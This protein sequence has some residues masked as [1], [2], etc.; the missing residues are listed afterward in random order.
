[1]DNETELHGPPKIFVEESESNAESSP[2]MSQNLNFGDKES[3]LKGSPLKAL[4]GDSKKKGALKVQFESNDNVVLETR[5]APGK[6][7]KF[8]S[9]KML[10]K[11]GM[12]KK[13]KKTVMSKNLTRHVVTRWYRAPEVILMNKMYSYSVDIWSVGCIFTELLTMM[14]TNFANWTDRQPLFPGQACYPLSPSQANATAEEKEKRQ[15]MDQLGK[16]FEVIGTPAP[17]ENIDWI[18]EEESKKYV[19]S[20]ASRPKVNLSDLYPG[21]ESRG[22]E[23]LHKMLEFNP[24]KRISAE[25]AIADPYFDDIRLPE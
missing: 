8:K 11:P 17:D 7:E 9:S 23:L 12:M 21:T 20:F 3:A 22:I 4:K 24:N 18:N 15:N 25:E 2:L 10:Q 16:I 1:M 14:E 5:K 19:K 13:I 6:M